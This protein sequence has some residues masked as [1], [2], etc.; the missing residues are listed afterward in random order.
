MCIRDRKKLVEKH[1]PNGVDIEVAVRSVGNYVDRAQ[2]VLAHLRKVG[3]RGTLRTHESAAGYA[4]F[5]KGDFT[6]IASQDRSMDVNDPAGVFHI[7]YTTEAGSNYGHMSDPKID[8]LAD[9]ALRESN[10]EKRKQLYWELQ[11]YIL[12]RGDAGSVAVAWVEGWFFKD[13]RLRNY[14]PGLTTYDNN[15][16]MKVWLAQ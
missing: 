10:R 4:S 16:F 8:E 6:L 3:I 11:R 1:H 14:K 12:S 7:A 9:R 2:L 5:G 15:T 13:K